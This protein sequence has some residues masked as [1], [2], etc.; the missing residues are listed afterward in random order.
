MTDE[1]LDGAWEELTLLSDI[2]ELESEAVKPSRRQRRIKKRG[3]TDPRRK[4]TLKNSPYQS[5]VTRL[6]SEY[7][8]ATNM[9]Q[10]SII[11]KMKELVRRRDDGGD[12]MQYEA[13]V[14]E[15]IGS[16]ALEAYLCVNFQA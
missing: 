16:N 3:N 12:K 2:A 11:A 7:S 5:S 13:A 9:K 1:E 6:V 10:V 8:S 14:A 4:R 15:F